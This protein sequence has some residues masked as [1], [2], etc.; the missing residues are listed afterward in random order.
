MHRKSRLAAILL[1]Y[2]LISSMTLLVSCAS[3]EDKGGPSPVAKETPAAAR[4]KGEG[5]NVVLVTI[6]TL[7]ADHLG[8]YGHPKIR[9]PNLDALA[10]QGARFEMA[11]AQFSQ[12]NPSHA[13][14]LTGLYAATHKVKVHGVDKVSPSVATLAEVLAG[15]GYVTAGIYS[16]PSFDPPMS[17]LDRGFATYRGVY[18]E[19]TGQQGQQDFWR[20]WDGRADA[21]TDAALQWLRGSPA[22]PFFLWLHYQ[23]PHYPFTPP[24]PFDT[25][26]DPDC[27][28]CADGGWNTID[29]IHA[30]ERFSE[31]DIAHVVAQYDGEISS[32]DQEIG[33]LLDGLRQANLLSNTMVIVTADHGESFNDNGR[34]FHPLILYNSVLRVPL[35]IWYPPAVPEGTVVDAVAQSI[36]IVPTILELA[37]IALPAQVEGRSLLP[38]VLG[39]EKGDD[40]MAFAQV[41]DDSMIAL[42]TR[43]WKLIRNN[44][45]G[46]LELYNLRT[47]PGE[48][49]NLALTNPRQ[50]AELAQKLKVWMDS[51]GI[52]SSRP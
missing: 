48:R 18:Q 24:P 10:R 9:T 28:N 7:R 31:R 36:D 2:L 12:T 14:I 52:G 45:S 32:T 8:S 33:R 19:V 5:P 6:D 22:A 38:L 27:H 41:P 17:G 16:W 34:W 42:A 15:Q 4:P 11:M 29:R 23:D 37:G 30:G 46:E 35:L 1:P 50:A 44:V 47:D 49:N 25:M 43:E 40:R 3:G 20:R 26:Y 39:R 51:H 21:T 13:S